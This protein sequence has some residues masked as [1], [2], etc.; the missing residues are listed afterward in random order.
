MLATSSLLRGAVL[1]G[2]VVTNPGIAA[3]MSTPGDPI[4]DIDV[5]VE[6]H[7]GPRLQTKTDVHGAFSFTLSAGV[8]VVRVWDHPTSAPSPT[9]RSAA[10]PSETNGRRVA[11]P[12]SVTGKGG[13]PFALRLSD[14]NVTIS[15][16]GLAAPPPAAANQRT[17]PAAGAILE[18]QVTVGPAMARSGAIY[19]LRGS[20]ERRN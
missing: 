13:W 4:P 18:L 7:P 12:D 14:A 3:R 20:V 16:I 8:Y 2:T 5:T 19:T 10:P 15:R 17:A 1:A 11:L 6:Q 9:E